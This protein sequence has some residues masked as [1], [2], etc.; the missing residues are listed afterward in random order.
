MAVVIIP[1]LGTT[2]LIDAVSPDDYILVGDASDG[3]E[4]KRALIESLP[5][6]SSGKLAIADYSYDTIPDKPSTFPADLIP[7]TNLGTP[8]LIVNPTNPSAYFYQMES[9]RK[10]IVDTQGLWEFRLPQNP[11][12]GDTIE[13]QAIFGNGMI[14]SAIGKINFYNKSSG[15]QLVRGLEN[16][17]Y[18]QIDSGEAILLKDFNGAAIYANMYA[19]YETLAIATINGV[20]KVFWKSIS[21]NTITLW[22]MDSN[23]RLVEGFDS[24]LASPSAAYYEELFQTSLYQEQEIPY[25][26]TVNV[27]YSRLRMKNLSGISLIFTGLYWV[28]RSRIG[29]IVPLV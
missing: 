24:G 22:N 27:L 2:P 28:V 12:T 13:F 8:D 11:N 14:S 6:S 26:S 19:G 1:N 15:L 7:F 3:G 10:Y 9:N 21:L 29:S 25:I 17:Y 4:L 23:W 5:D 20:N 18:A 16:K